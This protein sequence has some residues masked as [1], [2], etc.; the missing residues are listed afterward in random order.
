MFMGDSPSHL[1]PMSTW[2]PPEIKKKF[3]SL[4]KIHGEPNP[5]RLL[6]LLVEYLV[7]KS[8]YPD[9]D[10]VNFKKGLEE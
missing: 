10:L 3:K 7:A 4:C 8:H 2:V 1:D 9:P 6:R 5:S